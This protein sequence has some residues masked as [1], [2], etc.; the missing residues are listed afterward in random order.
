MGRG[1]TH[2]TKGLG[3]GNVTGNHRIRNTARMNKP[4]QSNPL[5]INYT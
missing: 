1:E 5:I 2:M 4:F 3:A